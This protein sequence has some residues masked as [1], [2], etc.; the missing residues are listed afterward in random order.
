MST[1]DTVRKRKSR[2]FKVPLPSGDDFVF[3][4]TLSGAERQAFRVMV[5]ASGEGNL[6]TDT[7]V[8]LALCEEDG[9]RTY[10]HENGEHLSEIREMDGADVDHIAM[11]F[12]KLSGLRAADVEEIE[13][14]SEAIPNG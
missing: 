13:K 5:D 12:L 7:I 3:V 11:S 1:R 2:I 8:A 4:R 10:D 14:K 9:K 6:K